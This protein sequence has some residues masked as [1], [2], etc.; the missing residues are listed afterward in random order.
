MLRC[1]DCGT[2]TFQSHMTRQ[3][4]RIDRCKTCGGAWFDQGTIFH[5]ARSASEFTL[6]ME[7]ARENARESDRLSP[8]TNEPLMGFPLV[9]EK[10]V[11]NI[12]PKTGGLWLGGREM[13][14]LASGD[15]P[16]LSI[17]FDEPGEG[18]PEDEAPDE[19]YDP[20]DEGLEEVSVKTGG[21]LKPL[22]NL[23]LRS[24]AT[25][26]FL[27][28]L[29][30]LVLI[31]AVEFLGL[32]PKIALLIGIGFALLQFLI[33]PF[34]M[35]ITLRWF[36]S[37]HWVKPMEL[38]PHLSRFILRVCQESGMKVP[39]FGIIEDGSPNAFTYGH[40]PGNARVVVTRGILDLLG[41]G[42]I[43]AVVAHEIGHAKHWDMVLMTVAQLV[44][45]I[46]YYVYR[47]LI[48][49]K[50]K[51]NDEKGGSPYQ[52]A[53]AIG[54]YI[55]YSVSEYIVLW[56]SRTREYYADR[57]AGQV[58]GRPND[59]AQAL[60]KIAYGLAGQE[61]GEKG[62]KEKER[63][64]SLEAIGAFG[65]FD[66]KVARSLAVVSSGSSRSAGNPS[67][68]GIDRKTLLGAMRWDLWNPWAMFYELHSTHPLTAKRLTHLGEQA[69]SLGQEP[70]VIFNMKKPESYWDEFLVDFSMY[71]LPLLVPLFLILAG[72]LTGKFWLYGAALAGAG[73]GLFIKMPFSYPRKGFPAT[74]VSE[75]LKK[76]KVSGIRPVP[77]SLKGIV[78][79][80][81]V[82]GLIWSEDFVMQDRSGIIFLDYRQP[83]KIW[84]FFFG[85]LRGKKL[86]DAEVE[87]TGWYRRAPVPYV[88]LNNMRVG[89]TRY[90][91]YVY[92]IKLVLAALLVMVGLI[93]TL[94]GFM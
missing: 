51:K 52:L 41:E 60:V 38:P 48:G 8:V 37:M 62:G 81:G 32:A 67:G 88:E 33:S 50:S 9:Q 31:S 23:Y 42:E 56:F 68:G 69:S 72:L 79:G 76:V 21:P 77:C 12:C 19:S 93:V 78:I 85:L 26:F 83:S 17:R 71:S 65:I 53:A 29:V 94:G 44:P 16:F 63:K 30:A 39:R 3:G 87:V 2:E 15:G 13:E 66:P 82:P 18:S 5:F 11:M 7:Q 49:A 47:T 43:E 73:L 20:A 45:L 35:D 22:P 6:A 27:Y 46:L 28:A 4:V 80:R 36:Y 61:K 59:L 90:T 34:L 54:A 74:E 40:T 64:F 75:L 24:G 14:K 91:C 57:F 10:V 89:G 84:E 55:L 92:H 1:P 70:L 58:T 86:R 25:L